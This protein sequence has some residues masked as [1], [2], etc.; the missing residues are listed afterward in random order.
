MDGRHTQFLLFNTR[1]MSSFE[2]GKYLG[3]GVGEVLSDVSA[4]A[5]AECIT[6]PKRHEAIVD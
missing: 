2:T 4:T 5:V 3:K 1:V 6:L